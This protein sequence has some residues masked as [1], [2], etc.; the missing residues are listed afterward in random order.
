LFLCHPVHFCGYKFQEATTVPKV[1]NVTREMNVA[2]L[3]EGSRG[4]EMQLVNRNFRLNTFLTNIMKQMLN[5]EILHHSK[6]SDCQLERPL[7]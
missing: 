6:H 5:A 1:I 4:E 7:T 2:K 3:P